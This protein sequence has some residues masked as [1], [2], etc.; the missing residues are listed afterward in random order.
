MIKIN[1]PLLVQIIYNV[2]KVIH[3]FL[4][5]SQIHN[6]LHIYVSQERKCKWSPNEMTAMTDQVTSLLTR[7]NRFVLL[8]WV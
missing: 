5:N 4:H 6:T 3:V 2:F 7:L 1:K 8:S